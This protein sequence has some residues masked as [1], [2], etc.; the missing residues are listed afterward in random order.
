M[1][2]QTEWWI[3]TSKNSAKLKQYYYFHTEF[4][5]EIRYQ[6][7]AISPKLKLPALWYTCILTA[8]LLFP[9]SRSLGKEERSTRVAFPSV[10]VLGG[11][12]PPGMVSCSMWGSREVVLL[13]GGEGE[14]SVSKGRREKERERERKKGREGEEEGGRRKTEKKLHHRQICIPGKWSWLFVCRSFLVS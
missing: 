11:S 1:R 2:T 14:G 4:L 7:R 9:A 10:R 6:R 13:W 8:R 12:I 3:L 5:E